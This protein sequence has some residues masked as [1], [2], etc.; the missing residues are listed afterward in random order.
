V[1]N[2]LF[3]PDGVCRNVDDFR[4][5]ECFKDSRHDVVEF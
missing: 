5:S 1:G 2:G 3:N 4:L